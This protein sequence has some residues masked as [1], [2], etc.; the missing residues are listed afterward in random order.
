MTKPKA[1]IALSYVRPDEVAECWNG[2]GN[3]LYRAL[4]G[5]MK[6]VPK[7]PNIEDSGPA[8]HVGYGSV[9]SLWEH[10]SPEMAAELNALAEKEDAHA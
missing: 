6:F 9:A 2:V 4:W 10:V 5:L 3:D 1:H 7:T 8:D